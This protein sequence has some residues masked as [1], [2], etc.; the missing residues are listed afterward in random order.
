MGLTND[1]VNFEA[2]EHR[3]ERDNLYDR[4]SNPSRASIRSHISGNLPWSTRF[5]LKAK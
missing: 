5:S 3:S 4:F 2:K 1:P